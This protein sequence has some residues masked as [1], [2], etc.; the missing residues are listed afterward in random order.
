MPQPTT[1]PGRFVSRAYTTCVLLLVG[2]TSGVGVVAA[3]VEDG[4]VGAAWGLLAA[5]GMLL[6]FALV[7]ALAWPR[8][9]SPLVP[10]ATGTIEVTS[11]AVLGWF[12]V[13]SWLC[14]LAGAAVWAWVAVTDPS[15]VTE[16]GPLAV[17]GIGAVA[18]LPDLVR[19][20]TG[21]M[22]RWRVTLTP[23]TVS[24]QGYR[25]AVSEPWT[26]VA[27]VRVVRGRRVGVVVDLKA[28]RPD[29]VLPYTAF[30]V[31]PDVLA[32]EIAARS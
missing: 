6:E 9:T 28:S 19:L 4:L 32:R 21:R 10:D 22:H 12:L 29:L 18:S 26:A 16:A 25:R 5:A 1:E 23:E 7:V 30:L 2:V 13:G 11:P 8:R 31:R 24:Y 3:L 17:M 15:R 14:V 20:L 27:G